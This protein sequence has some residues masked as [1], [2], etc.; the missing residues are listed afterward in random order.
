VVEEVQDRLDFLLEMRELGYEKKYRPSIEQQVVAK[1]RQMRAIDPQRCQDLG[2][3]NH[4]LLAQ[5]KA[6]A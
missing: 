5:S 1:V 3:L 2:T 4:L 6:S